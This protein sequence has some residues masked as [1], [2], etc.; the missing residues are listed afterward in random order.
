MNHF[1]SKIIMRL[2][3]MSGIKR[4]RIQKLFHNSGKDANQEVPHFHS[5]YL[6]DKN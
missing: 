6:A 5:T 1:F 4:I 3:D 2:F